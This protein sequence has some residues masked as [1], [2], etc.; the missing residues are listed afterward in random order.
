[1]I[2]KRTYLQG[3]AALTIGLLLLFP[4]LASGQSAPSISKAEVDLW[5]EYDRPDVLVIY[6]LTLDPTTPLPAQTGVFIPASVGDPYNLAYVGPD[7]NL[8]NL[9]YT[10]T[11]K[12]DL[13]EISFSTPSAQIQLEYYDSTLI[14]NGTSRKFTFHWPQ[15]SPVGSLT[16][17][18]QQ[19]LGATDM[20][21]TPSL[22]SGASGDGGLI[23]Y[24]ATVGPVA[25]ETGFS[26]QLSYQKANDDLSLQSLK[27]Q[28]SA[29]IDAS[30]TGRLTLDDVLPWIIGAFGILLIGGGG[31]WYWQ[32]GRDNQP[33]RTRRRHELP[34]GKA[35]AGNGVQPGAVYCH[36][37]GKRAEPEDIFC[38]SCGARLRR[39][40]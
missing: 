22:G 33:N 2:R 7:G 16:M 11:A 35:P 14:K 24:T 34:A 18:V 37:C 23:Y 13:A 5:P 20:Q 32:S 4:S 28:P 12:G 26:L 15:N 40:E 21:I 19:P 30:T 39:E 8:Y 3:I 1:M 10:R 36:R 29:P 25:A 6:R 17:Q 38:R 27:V 31:W 9:N